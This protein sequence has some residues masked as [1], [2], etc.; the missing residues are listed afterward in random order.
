MSG[1]KKRHAEINI[2]ISHSILHTTLVVTSEYVYVG[3]GKWG[4]MLFDLFDLLSS[5]SL[6]GLQ[7]R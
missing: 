4:G 1:A 3:L 7:R 6:F 5:G 2:D